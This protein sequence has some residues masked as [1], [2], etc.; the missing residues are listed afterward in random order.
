[1]LLNTLNIYERCS[2]KTYSG[3][4]CVYSTS[5]TDKIQCCKSGV[6]QGTKEIIKDYAAESYLRHSRIKLDVLHV[7]CADSQSPHHLDTVISQP[8]HQA[9][10]IRRTRR[11]SYATALSK[12]FSNTVFGKRAFRCSALATWKLNSLARTVT[13][14]DTLGTF[15]SSPKTLLFCQAFY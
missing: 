12:P 14:S 3:V 11:T 6:S 15:K 8:T 9:R 1:V 13:D 4:G 7:G 5:A 10:D 2:R